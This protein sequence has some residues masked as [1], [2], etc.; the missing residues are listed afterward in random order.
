MLEAALARVGVD[1]R[2]WRALVGVWLAGDLRSGAGTVALSILAYLIPGALCAFFFWLIPDLFSA[3][4][5][6][7]G[8]EALLVAMLV[9]LDFQSLILSPT[10]YAVL[11]YRPVSSRTYLVARLTTAITYTALIVATFAVPPALACLFLRDPGTAA[12]FFV[13]AELLGVTVLLAGALL[14][15]ALLRLVHPDLLLRYLSYLQVTLSFLM[16]GGWMVVPALMD[17][18][19]FVGR[20]ELGRSAWI[21]LVPI[22]WFAALVGVPAGSAGPW[23]R[24]AGALALIAPIALTVIVCGRLSLTYA[25]RL[26]ALASTTPTGGR[27]GAAPGWLLGLFREREARAV[28]LLVW[29]QFR[30]DVKFRLAILGIV[31]MTLA[32]LWWGGWSGLADPFEP[33]V[34]RESQPML[35]FA[36]IFF[37][38][39]LKPALIGAESFRASWIFH[40]TPARHSKLVLAT[41]NAIAVYFILPYLAM[42]AAI[43]A[44]TYARPW[45]VVVHVG[46][47]GLVSHIMLQIMMIRDPALPFSRAPRATQQANGVMMTVM[48]GGFFA[49]LLPFV[50][51]VIYPYPVRLT[52]TLA[53]LVTLTCILEWCLVRRVTRR[54]E[55]FRYVDELSAA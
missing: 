5:L 15:I 45:H 25:L 53:V 4:L 55:H 24:V 20:I 28:A 44:T 32:Y 30:Y 27:G 9:M 8:Y 51:R 3:A 1:T 2:Q 14:Y 43:F 16:Y 47:L 35:Y 41:K 37:P 49:G 34:G 18:D 33:A 23:L 10:D 11:G 12:A 52:I 48:L 22:A 50:S 42:L 6:S 38:T 39:M 19:G 13:A 54:A 36:V 40:T 31:P 21:L 17:G 26:S 46:L 29:S 7:F